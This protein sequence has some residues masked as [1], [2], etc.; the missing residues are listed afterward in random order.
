MVEHGHRTGNTPSGD[1]AE[2]D[3]ICQALRRLP[4][5]GRYF[6]VIGSWIIRD[7]AA[8]IGIRESEQPITRN[9]SR[10]APHFF[11]P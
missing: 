10:F 4:D 1:G 8:G 5:M 6:P 3:Y 7:E 2:G 11:V 9:T